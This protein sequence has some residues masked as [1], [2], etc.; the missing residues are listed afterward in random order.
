[1]NEKQAAINALRQAAK[2][3]DNDY[4]WLTATHGAYGQ[5]KVRAGLRLAETLARRRADELEAGVPHK[6][7]GRPEAN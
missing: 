2:D 1:V 5:T 3:W 4:E 6:S 7:F